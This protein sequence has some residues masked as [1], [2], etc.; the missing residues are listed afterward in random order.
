MAAEGQLL[1]RDGRPR[2][3]VPFFEKAAAATSGPEPFIDLSHAYLAAT[4]P[5]R[6]RDAAAEA[7]RRSPGHPWAMAALGT[8]LVAQGQREQGLEYL[9]RGVSAGPRRP[10]VWE[11]LAEGFDAARDAPRAA[12]C[13]RQADALR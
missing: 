4:D 8:A 1:L 11:T 9:N 7:L 3:A 10:I 13:R 5:A 6:A 12:F 2:D